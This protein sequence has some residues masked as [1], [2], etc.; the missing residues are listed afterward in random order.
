MAVAWA[1]SLLCS[2]QGNLLYL[3]PYSPNDGILIQCS[4]GT[5]FPALSLLRELLERDELWKPFLF[6]S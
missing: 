3:R 1:L 5:L 2:P 4:Q 6:E